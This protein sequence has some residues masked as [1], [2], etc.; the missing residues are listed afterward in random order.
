M[1]W[2][3]MSAGCIAI[4]TIA[5]TPTLDWREVRPEGSGVRALF[6]CKP[7]RQVREVALAG[8]PVSMAMHA[9]NAGDAVYAL[10]FADVGDPARVSSALGELRR[11]A[12]RNIHAAAPEARPFAVAGMTPNAQAVRFRGSGHRPDGSAVE[13]DVSLFAHGTVVYQATVL[14]TA[15]DAVAAQTFVDGLAVPK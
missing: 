11:T 12:L 15:V 14:G 5:C 10:A 2:R 3:S 7:S 13:E 8:A 9:C 1:L 6:P 4:C